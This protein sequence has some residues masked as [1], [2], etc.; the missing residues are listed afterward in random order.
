MK[1]LDFRLRLF[2]CLLGLFLIA[3]TTAR[4][5]LILTHGDSFDSL[6]AGQ[7]LLAFLSGLKFDLATSATFVGIPFLM[8]NLPIVSR[9]WFKAWTLIAI[10]EFFLMVPIL[11]ADHIF[12]GHVKRH[13]GDEI[14]LIG[15]DLGFL[16]DFTL[17]GYVPHLIFALAA[18]VV[19]FM[20]LSKLIDKWYSKD[21]RFKTEPVRIL[22]VIFF[23]VMA[24][25]GFTFHGK[26][27]GVVDAFDYGSSEYGNVVLN[28]V[29]T[30]YQSSRSS[31][32]IN[33]NFFGRENAI[34]TAQ[35]LVV[36][37]DERATDQN[38]PLMRARE[39][40]S[41][42][43]EGY[44]VVLILL[45]SWSYKFI[46]SF[47]R[48]DFGA[49]P[50]FDA[51]ANNGLMF[52]DFYANGQRSIIGIAA[53]L[54]GIPAV[55]GMPTL[56]SG[57]E[58]SNITRIGTVLKDRDYST[59]FVQTSKRGS[60]RMEGIASAS[61]FD[62]FYGKQDI[63]LIYPYK[64]DEEPA[65]GFDYDGL[66]FLKDKLDGAG[67]P[68]FAVFFSGTTH[69]PYILLDDA[70]QKYPH[71]SHSLNGYL[72]TLYYSD[73]SIGEFF[74][75]VKRSSWFENTIFI[76]TADHALGQ[77]QGNTI[78]DKFSIP[79]VLYCPKLFSHR[80]IGFPSSQADIMPTIMEMLNLKT[81]YS[82]IGKSL[83]RDYENRFVFF[84]EGNNIGLITEN[85]YLK[86]SLKTRLE[87]RSF[88]DGFD[89]N[90]AEKS[91]LSIDEALYTLLKENRWYAVS[92]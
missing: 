79:L 12:F 75:A 9:K 85:G 68:F 23:L 56:G 36:E 41:V 54:T 19:L 2:L 78:D 46:D 65:F 30:S 24:I 38:Y 5:A 51:L 25:R 69:A 59:I 15:N 82:A 34:N 45:E 90:E 57:L 64:T 81:S 37:S 49:T 1:Y 42:N 43:A 87:T 35:G 22:A 48:S 47:S 31:K 58:L 11:V 61:G 14:K 21:F 66:M 77:F 27:I 10:I 72:N 53:S 40:F 62:E 3:F 4:I 92:R 39:N 7:L 44:N 88:K 84:T 28:G 26:P 83:L 60:F 76:L 80:K 71:G 52:T 29:F 91:L 50:N 86:H 18:S 73:Y 89:A 16:L 55:P 67:K 33:H 63:P 17:K 13:I 20:L 70:F 6:V 32:S 8:M 74:K